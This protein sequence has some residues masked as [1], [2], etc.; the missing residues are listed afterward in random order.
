MSRSTHLRCLLLPHS[1]KLQKMLAMVQS[2]SSYVQE[3]LVQA[4]KEIQL[5]VRLLVSRFV[6]EWPDWSVVSYYAIPMSK[7]IRCEAGEYN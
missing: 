1:R 3:L 7:H 6:I 5:T 4:L 2:Q